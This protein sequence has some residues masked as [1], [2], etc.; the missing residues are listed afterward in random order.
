M[1][2]RPV[3]IEASWKEFERTVIARNKDR[4]PAAVLQQFRGVYFAG[5]M[6]VLAELSDEL[7]LLESDKAKAML[8]EMLFF[9]FGQGS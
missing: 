2:Q 1:S 5:A 4:I 6:A 8:N 7:A 3:L 9:S